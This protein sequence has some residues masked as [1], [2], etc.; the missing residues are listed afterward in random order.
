MNSEDS[1]VVR[2]RLLVS[3]VLL[4][5]AELGACSN[6]VPTSML[7]PKPTTPVHTATPQPASDEEAIRQLILLEGQGVVSQ[8]IDGLMGL[9]AEDAVVADA[10][11]TPDDG[12]DD[13]RWQGRDAIRERYVVLVFPG[14]P[15]A[16]GATDVAIT[17]EGYTAVAT[18]T[19]VIGGEVSPGGDRWT[20]AKRD[21][22][23]W[24]TGLTYNLEAR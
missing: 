3:I 21:G 8:D 11:H 6:A 15:T 13:A 12:T 14:N 2:V 23:W 10:R 24:I 16:A 18:S 17:I 1:Q 19:T 7:G 4:A 22:R 20:F 9:W 5:L